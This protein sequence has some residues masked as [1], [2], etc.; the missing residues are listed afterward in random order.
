[1]SSFAQDLTAAGED[2]TGHLVVLGD[3]GTQRAV[4]ELVDD[5]LDVVRLLAAAAW[6]A[7]LSLTER[8]A[9]DAADTP[10]AHPTPR[11]VRG[12]P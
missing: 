5:V 3:R 11:S 4:D 8:P 2:L 6:E 7:S 10:R 9:T 1:M 12:A